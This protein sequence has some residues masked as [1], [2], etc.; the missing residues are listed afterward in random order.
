VDPLSPS[1]LELRQWAFQ[2]AAEK[3]VTEKSPAFP[4]PASMPVNISGWYWVNDPSGCGIA[5]KKNAA[6]DASGGVELPQ[7]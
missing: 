3:A 2:Y 4:R 1:P 7:T 5:P 6:G